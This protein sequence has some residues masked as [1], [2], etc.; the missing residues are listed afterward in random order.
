MS[1]QIFLFFVLFCLSFNLISQT[2]Q[3]IS[4]QAVARNAQ[5][6]IL[7]N[8]N[9]SLRVSILSGSVSGSAVYV[10][11]HNLSTN[12]YGLINIQIGKG[13]ASSGVFSSIDWGANSYYSKV[14]IDIAGGTNYSE[15]GVSQILSVPYAL[16]SDKARIATEDG[17][18]NSSN[19]LQSL[20]I[21]GTQLSISKGNTVTLP[22]SGSGSVEV[23]TSAQRDA[24]TNIPTGKMIFN[25]NTD[26]LEIYN[27]VKWVGII[28]SK[29][30]ITSNW[31]KKDIAV[32]NLNRDTMQSFVIQN[33]LYYFSCANT[34]LY[35]LDLTTF[36]TTQ[37]NNLPFTLTKNSSRFVTNSYAYVTNGGSLYQY[38]P[39]TDS[40]LLR[41]TPKLGLYF[42]IQ[43][44]AFVRVTPRNMFGYPIS[45]DIYEYNESSDTWILNSSFPPLDNSNAVYY[46]S[47]FFS[48]SDCSF[49][50]NSDRLFEFNATNKTL[51]QKA[52]PSHPLSNFYTVSKTDNASAY[53]VDGSSFFVY[54]KAND[55][56]SSSNNAFFPSL[57]QKT[58]QFD[59]NGTYYIWDNINGS[60][61]Y[62][63]PN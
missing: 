36:L 46:G 16:Y 52:T 10:E 7:S 57:E 17:D 62:F 28:T 40:W 56:W 13:T 3:A 63:T 30:S 19:E 5:G 18:S 12:Q 4:Y 60:L 23:L 55:K 33:K 9:V 15:V 2:P 6:N 32:I 47:S 27:G 58:I 29:S 37:K 39:S 42:V 38:N 31:S 59:L 44:K 24:L 8:T 45:D 51:T 53:Q 54:Q 26:V 61:W 43:N 50:V 35:S 49:F 41:N 34:N 21:T 11:T 48:I 1:K 22:S 25:T 20:S 14:D